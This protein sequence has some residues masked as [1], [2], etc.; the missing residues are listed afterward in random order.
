MLFE[1]LERYGDVLRADR[2]L[3]RLSRLIEGK[4][5]EAGLVAAHAERLDPGD[6]LR[7][8]DAALDRQHLR[9]I[10][11]ARLFRGEKPLH[12]LDH[13]EHSRF[14][15]IEIPVDPPQKIHI[16]AHLVVENRDVAR[17]LIS[18][19]D[20]ILILVQLEK[21]PAHRDDIV[22][23]MGREDDDILPRRQL[24]PPANLRDQRVEDFAVERTRGLVAREQRAQVMLPVV[25]TVEL[26]NGF[27]GYFAQPDHGRDFEL[28]RPFHFACNPRRADARQV[29][30]CGVVHVENGVG[31][32]LQVRRSDIGIRLFLHCPP[33]YH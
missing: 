4:V 15:H 33:D 19:D 26:E 31:M 29:G 20:S 18:N 5:E 28:A 30:R 7:L 21:N 8:A 23:G 22:I 24:A 3:P 10:H 9:D 11:L 6:C 12:F 17:G 13:R 16:T 32:E 2:I 1:K 27:P 25:Q 14:R